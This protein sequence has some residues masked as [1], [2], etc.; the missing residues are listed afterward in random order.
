MMGDVVTYTETGDVAWI[1]LNRPEKLNALNDAVIFGLR[2]AIARAEA[3]DAVGAMVLHGNGR[4]FSAGGDISAFAVTDEA[5][6]SLTIRALM[7]LATDCCSS[8]KP[9][10]GALHGYVMAGGFE[11]AINCD[12]RLAAT[13]TVFGLPDTPL[14]LSPTS[15]MTYRLPRIIGLGRAMHLTLSAE[16]IDAE[17]AERI[18]FTSRTVAPEHL[19]EE[20]GAL[21]RKIA[22]FPRVGV[23]NT[24]LLYH[25]ALETDFGSAASA[26]FGAEMECFASDEVRANFRRFANRKK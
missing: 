26:E 9:I 12:I 13:G 23:R 15:G 11:L 16:N 21:A 5:G 20:A 14:G 19:L 10:I 7:D 1:A 2:A 25:D 8:T 22:S 4:A 6:F 24:K 17:E 18:G 3:S